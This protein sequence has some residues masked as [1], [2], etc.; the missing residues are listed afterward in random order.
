[1]YKPGVTLLAL[2]LL[3][4]ALGGCSKCGDFIFAQPN[5]CH[6]GAPVR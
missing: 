1:M 5:A 6:S 2:A 4:A 3:A